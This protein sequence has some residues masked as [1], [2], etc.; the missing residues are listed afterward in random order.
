M[1]NK[2]WCECSR[3]EQREFAELKRVYSKLKLAYSNKAISKK[4]YQHGLKLIGKE[5]NKLEAK[6][7]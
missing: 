1:K 2:L 3:K 5:L 4:E 6:Y 7:D